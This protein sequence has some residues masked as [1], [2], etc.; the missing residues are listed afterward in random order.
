MLPRLNEYK[1]NGKSGTVP[2]IQVGLLHQYNLTVRGP[3]VSV[4][5]SAAASL[6]SPSLFAMQNGAISV[7]GTF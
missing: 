3:A 6:V 4:C 5:F 2:S 7:A 1:Q